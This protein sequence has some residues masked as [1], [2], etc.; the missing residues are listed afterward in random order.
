M[1]TLAKSLKFNRLVL[2]EN[3]TNLN[4]SVGFVQI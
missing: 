1:E 4:G 3:S 2:D